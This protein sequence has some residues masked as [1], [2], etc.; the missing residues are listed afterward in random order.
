MAEREKTEPVELTNMV[1]VYD[2]QSNRAVVQR[3]VKSWK[4]VT[5]PGGHVE[6]EESLVDSAVR[7]VKEETG[8]AISQLEPCGVIHWST[9]HGRPRYLV[10][11]YKTCHYQGQLLAATDEG[12]VWW[13]ELDT[14]PQLDLCK[15]FDLY[16]P[17][18]L[19]GGYCEVYGTGIEADD[20]RRITYK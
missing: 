11:L 12:A 5:F 4:G 17:L 18:F 15:N 8:L 1:M 10:F 6:P 9:G 14:L 20:S 16:L 3:R 19:E 2:P 13:Q 7:E